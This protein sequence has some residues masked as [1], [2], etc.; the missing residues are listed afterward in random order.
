MNRQF[1]FR[2][3]VSGLYLV[4]GCVLGYVGN[5]T[6]NFRWFQERTIDLGAYDWI[7]IF[8]ECWMYVLVSVDSM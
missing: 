5:R 2:V 8:M 4:V 6:R 1:Q 7:G 3:C